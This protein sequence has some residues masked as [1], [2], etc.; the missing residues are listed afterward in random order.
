M[1]VSAPS[2][3]ARPKLEQCGSRSRR[4]PPRGCSRLD[5]PMDDPRAM[6]VRERVE[7]L[8]GDLDGVAVGQCT[9]ADRLAERPPGDVLV[10]DVDVARVVPDV[11]RA[12]A[13]VVAQASRSHRLALGARGRLALPR[14]DLQRDVEA[15]SARRARATPIPSRPFPAAAWVDSARERASRGMGRP[16]RSTRLHSLPPVGRLLARLS[17][18]PAATAGF[19]ALYLRLCLAELRACNERGRS[20]TSS[21]GLEA[22]A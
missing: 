15:V 14:D 12:D 8:R 21:G 11:V 5:V 18:D 10:R 16:R 19:R 20:Y 7:H 17:Y 4:D 1:S 2:N 9:G 6:C 3:W 22:A 13:A